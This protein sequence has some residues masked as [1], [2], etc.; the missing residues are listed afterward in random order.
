MA[1]APRRLYQKCAISSSDQVPDVAAQERGVPVVE[2][3]N[4]DG[5][6]S[7]LHA[8]DTAKSKESSKW[9]ENQENAG[10]ATEVSALGI[11]KDTSYT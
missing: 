11:L 6:H 8:S 2:R 10:G 3:P 9:P 5:Y 1:R 7:D 4:A